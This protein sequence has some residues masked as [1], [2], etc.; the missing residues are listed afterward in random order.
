MY[1]GRCLEP[2]LWSASLDGRCPHCG[3]LSLWH[4]SRERAMQRLEVPDVRIV[5]LGTPVEPSRTVDDPETRVP[6]ERRSGLAISKLLDPT[7]WDDNDDNDGW[8]FRL[9]LDDRTFLKVQ[10]IARD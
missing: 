9:T 2:S 4:S 6:P 3:K 10:R 1:C 8:P 5:P 7:R